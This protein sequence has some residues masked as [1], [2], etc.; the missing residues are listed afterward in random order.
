M[1]SG[2][3]VTPNV[4]AAV[5]TRAAARIEAKLEADLKLFPPLGTIVLFKLGAELSKLKGD[6]D[7]TK[8]LCNV[9]AR[10]LQTPI[11]PCQQL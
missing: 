7:G 11:Q 3:M 8:L 9:G 1:R 6:D 2:P 10:A 5:A 4:L